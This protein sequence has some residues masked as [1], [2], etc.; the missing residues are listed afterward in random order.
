MSASIHLVVNLP[1]GSV[2]R[3]D[4][5][6]GEYLIGRESCCNVIINAPMVSRRHARFTLSPEII[7]VEDLGSRAGTWLNETRATEPLQVALPATVSLGH[8]LL[9]VFS[10]T[11]PQSSD[12]GSLGS[13]QDAT[14]PENASQPPSSIV[15]ADPG[16]AIG[17]T[18]SASIAAPPPIEGLSEQAKKRLE[19]LY[20]L[21]LQLAAEQNLERLFKLILDRVMSLIPGAVRG[22]LLLKEHSSGKLSLC[23]SVPEGTPP[24]S[25]TLIKRAATEH[26]GFIWGDE[27]SDQQNLSASMAAIQIRTGMY[28]PLMW[29]EDSIG[30]LFVDN[31]NRRKAFDSED[32]RFLLSVANYAAAA[33]ANRL[34]QDEIEQNNQ[35][36]QNLLTNFSPKVRNRLLNKSREGK[37]QPG[38]EKSVVTILLSDLRGFTRTSTALDAQVVVDMLNDYFHALGQEIFRHDGTIDKFIGDAILAVFGSPEPDEHHVW[39]ALQAA[40]E[41]QRQMSAVNERRK[42]QG[43][44]FCELGIG[45][46]TGE[47][48]HGFIGAEDRL[49]YTVIGDT[50]NKA[51]RYCDGAQGGDIVLGPLSYEHLRDH[52]LAEYREIPTKHEGNLPAYVVDW[53]NPGI[54]SS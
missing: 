16:G 30:V 38:G 52:V 49:E 40:V 28:V 53:R 8:L 29:K 1:D 39:R 24:I 54:L 47:V 27:E 34:L 17:M 13:G 45:I 43:L 51:S 42:A 32:L 44:P 20:E 41:M 2:V 37:L 36:L 12:P 9:E 23:A 19:L 5:D 22:A 33:V 14:T 35:T 4:L 21:P 11:H 25:R 46:Y 10:D 18:L 31:P 50:V 48:L 7:E 6:A 15:Y 3:H 26:R